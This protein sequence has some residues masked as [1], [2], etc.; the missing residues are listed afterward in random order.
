[1]DVKG[2]FT[3]GVKV[4]KFGGSSLAD[5]NQF[6]RVADII[7]SEPERRYIVASAP[8]K[9]R[10]GDTKVTDLLY[11]CYELASNDEDIN[12]IGSTFHNNTFCI[13]NNN[14]IFYNYILRFQRLHKLLLYH[15]QLQ[16]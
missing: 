9:R 15:F 7:K 8:G 14:H 11:Q 6:R 16:L 10:S 2:E 5:A 1:M 13:H 4:L 12:N 3:M